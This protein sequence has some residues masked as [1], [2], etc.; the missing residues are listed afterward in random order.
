MFVPFW[1]SKQYACHHTPFS[2]ILIS[3]IAVIFAFVIFKCLIKMVVDIKDQAPKMP[4]THK[5]KPENDA[6]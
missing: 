4:S 3:P 5:N 1:L 6:H 2:D